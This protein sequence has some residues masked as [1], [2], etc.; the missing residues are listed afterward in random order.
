MGK[1]FKRSQLSIKKANDAN[2]FF[3]LP[4]EPN[5]EYKV[6]GVCVMGDEFKTPGIKFEGVDKPCELWKLRAV[7]YR[8]TKGPAKTTFQTCTDSEASILE[9]ELDRLDTDDTSVQPAGVK[10][11]YEILAKPI[12]YFDKNDQGRER[13]ALKVTITK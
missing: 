5:K 3:T 13:P 4:I 6:V 9:E 10:V 11:K 8:A 2:E 12:A 1:N 7:S